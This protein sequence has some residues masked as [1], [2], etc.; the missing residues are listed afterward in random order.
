[1]DALDPENLEEQFARL[2][3]AFA[4]ALATGHPRDPMTDADVP[5]ALRARLRDA[6]AW[7][8]HLQAL[9]AQTRSAVYET[10]SGGEVQAESTP[11]EPSASP[12]QRFRIVRFHD[13]GGLGDVF[14]ARDEEL[15]REVA[16]KELQERHAGSPQM[17]VRFLMEGEITGG[18]EHPGIV[19][20]YGMGLYPDGRPF[21]AMRF[22]R[23]ESLKSAIDKFHNDQSLERAPGEKAVAFRELLG[24]TVAVCHAIAY[25]HSRGVI[26]R[27]IKPANVMLGKYGETLVVDWGLAKPIGRSEAEKTDEATLRPDLAS[28]SG[29]TRSGSAVG[30]VPF[31]SPEAAAGRLEV[32]GPASDVYSLGA[33]LYCLLTGR[34]PFPET[35]VRKALQEIQ[36]GDFPPPRQVDRAVPAALQAVCLKAMALQPDD[37]YVSARALAD[38]LER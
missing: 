2:L 26:H 20:V 25:A 29:K 24:R 9:W 8:E 22:I 11:A 23:G 34:V 7:L 32:L 37:R 19:P 31:M 16:L 13:S 10:A 14:L 12:G 5:E 15:H 33:T 35:N 17:R 3:E 30:T 6:L 28:D 4:E 27:D 36:R 1:M 21:Y 18:L 38:D